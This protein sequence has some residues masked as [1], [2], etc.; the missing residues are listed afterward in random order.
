M[1]NDVVESFFFPLFLAIHAKKVSS[2]IGKSV[3]HALLGESEKVNI[4]FNM[5]L[6]NP[7]FDELMRY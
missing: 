1:C 3:M 7:A 6:F 5:I 2:I 4:L